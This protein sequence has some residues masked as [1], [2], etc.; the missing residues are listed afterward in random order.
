MEDMNGKQVTENSANREL[1]R[2][3]SRHRT[4]ADH[5]QAEPSSQD[6]AVEAS[7]RGKAEANVD[8]RYLSHTDIPRSSPPSGVTELPDSS[9]GYDQD[10]V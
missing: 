7:R 8:K 6:N 4:V 3:R 9:C 5:G 1:S 2:S 10:V